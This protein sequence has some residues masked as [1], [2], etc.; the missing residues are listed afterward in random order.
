[1]YNRW[2]LINVWLRTINNVWRENVQSR[3][4]ITKANIKLKKLN[5]L[6]LLNLQH[7]TIIMLENII[8]FCYRRFL[9]VIFQFYLQYTMY[10]IMQLFKIY[11]QY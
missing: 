5:L 7:E 3:M 9:G 4:F 10:K 2:N 11:C 8:F 6:N 1:M